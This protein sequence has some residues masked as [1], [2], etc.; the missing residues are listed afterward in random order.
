MCRGGFGWVLL[1]LF[2]TCGL[3]FISGAYKETHS[4][5]QEMEGYYKKK[6]KP[7]PLDLSN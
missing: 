5:T 4:Q 1:P 2:S 7:L 3:N 6:R